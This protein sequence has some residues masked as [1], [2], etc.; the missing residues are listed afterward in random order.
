MTC[1]SL[2]G[3]P[4]QCCLAGYKKL[5]VFILGPV[6]PI[7]RCTC[8]FKVLL[9]LHIF[10]RTYQWCNAVSYV[11]WNSLVHFIS[12]WSFLHKIAKGSGGG[13]HVSLHSIGLLSPLGA[14]N[15]EEKVQSSRDDLQVGTPWLERL[16]AG[17]IANYACAMLCKVLCS[18]GAVQMRFSLN[19]STFHI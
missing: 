15:G 19:F 6:G 10:Y 7:S 13:S 14:T 8:M 17:D 3:W 1:T 4:P 18:A 11:L 2:Y 12:L 16:A 5:Q 9:L